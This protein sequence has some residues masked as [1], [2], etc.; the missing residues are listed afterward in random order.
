MQPTVRLPRVI[1]YGTGE[2]C[3]YYLSEQRWREGKQF[4]ISAIADSDPKKWGADFWGY[5]VCKLDEILL[6]EFDAIVIMTEPHYFEIKKK[7]VYDLYLDERRIWRLDE[8]VYEL[9]REAACKR[10]TI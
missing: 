4:T 6:M 9:G 3:S 1:L 8:F 5:R 10:E 2:V 7:L